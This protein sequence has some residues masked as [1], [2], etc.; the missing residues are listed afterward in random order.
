MRLN[1]KKNSPSMLPGLFFLLSL[2]LFDN[3]LFYF[4]FKLER[5]SIRSRSSRL[6]II[7]PIAG[8]AEG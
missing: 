2:K 8:I 3:T 7:R 5:Y 6:L 4:P 1:A